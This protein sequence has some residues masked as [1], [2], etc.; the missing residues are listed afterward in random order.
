MK[1]TVIK[2]EGLMRSYEVTIPANDLDGALETKLKAEATDISLPGFRKGKVPMQVLKQRYSRMVMGEVIENAVNGTNQKIFKDKGIKPAL[3]PKI[4]IA[5]DYNFGKDLSYTM[6][7]EVLPEI[8]L[9]DVSKIKLTRLKA[10]PAEKEINEAM[11]RIAK[12]RK[13]TAPIKTD[14]A[15]KKGDV[16]IIDFDGES[17][18]VKHS[19]MSAEGFSL[20]LGSGSFIPG[21]EDQ[22]IGKKAGDEVNVEVTFPEKYGMKDLAGKD[23]TFKTKIHEIRETVTPEINDEFAKTLGLDSLDALKEALK[24]Q[25]QKEYDAV[26]RQKVKKDLLDIL[27]ENHKFKAPQGMV[28]ME[29][30]SIAHQ[31]HHQDGHDHNHEEGHDCAAALSVEEKKEVAELADR[32][33]RLGIVLAEIGNAQKIA[34]A[35]AD[36]QQAVIKEAQKY[37]GQEAQVFDYFKNN[38][39]ALEQIKAPIFEEKTVDYLLETATVTEKKVTMEEL[40]KD[41]DAEEEQAKA[42]KK[43]SGSAKGAMSGDKKPAAKKA[44]AKKAAAKK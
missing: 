38:P 37:P 41:D 4:E 30:D 17:G 7:V 14:R 20:E 23:A 16:L 34:I 28:D 24:E 5:K 19:G 12:Q 2:E 32:R 21:F 18:G 25:A 40:L 43:A 6:E 42:K 29:F 31:M 27:D 35:D 8:K 26:S 22:L 13:A 33:V 1:V 3:Q 15:T 10:E 39:Q 36:V 9:M 44:P 11:N